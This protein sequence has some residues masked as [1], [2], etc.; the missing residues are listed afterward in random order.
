MSTLVSWER[1]GP[2]PQMSLSE[3]RLLASY[4]LNL[5]KGERFVFETMI[6]DIQRHADL[7]ASELVNDAFLVF[8]NFRAKPTPFAAAILMKRKLH[9]GENSAPDVVGI[10]RREHERL[11]IIS[12]LAANLAHS[13]NQPL[14]A[15]SIYL[16]AAQRLTAGLPSESV[17]QIVETLDKAM[18]QIMC[19]SHVIHSLSQVVAQDEQYRAPISLNLLIEETLS[20]AA[21]D[22]TDAGVRISKQLTKDDDCVLVDRI[23]IEHVLLNLIQNAFE[24]MRKSQKRE[25]HVS[26]ATATTGFIRVE[27]QDT[28]C[29]PNGERNAD[30]LERCASRQEGM[31]VELFTSRAIVEAHNG[32]L[33]AKANPEGG[34][35]YYF[36]LPLRSRE[37]NG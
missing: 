14:T 3:E 32:K 19:A 34:A 26:S 2:E 9:A 25:L 22:A 28:G 21:A 18:A 33:R 15:A 30:L 6:S 36:D 5:Q 12:G 13:I 24:A 17:I 20:L 31:G 11:R 7:E 35:T 37:S 8:E 4:L 16:R 23:Q 1:S 27:F 29:R 10:S